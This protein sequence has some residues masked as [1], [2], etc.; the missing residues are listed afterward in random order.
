MTFLKPYHTTRLST[1]SPQQEGLLKTLWENQKIL[2][3]SIFFFF[4]FFFFFFSNN[5]LYPSINIFQFLSH[6]I[7]SSANDWNSLKLCRLVKSRKAQVITAVKT[8]DSSNLLSFFKIKALE[9]LECYM[10]REP[11][12]GINNLKK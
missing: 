4:F 3:T 7:F 11:R 10:S 1:P 5:V 9:A 6:I 2:V 8:R 12:Q